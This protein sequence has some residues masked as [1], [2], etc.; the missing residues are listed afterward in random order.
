MN[1]PYNGDEVTN[2]DVLVSLL[3]KTGSSE[4]QTSVH[5]L[6]V[7]LPTFDFATIEAMAEHSGH[8]RNK[9]IC[10]LITV[11]LS[12]VWSALD[13]ENGRAINNLRMNIY[14]KLI[15]GE[16]GNPEK[17]YDLAKLPQAEK[18]EV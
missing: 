8:S 12:E 11:A 17:P 14:Q 4:T 7:R 6:S 5:A 15:G 1:L 10:Q 16:I 13:E 2:L 18:G 9:I 3:E